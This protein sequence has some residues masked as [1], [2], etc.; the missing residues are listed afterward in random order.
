M[1]MLLI[2]KT[3]LFYHVI[4]NL[5]LNFFTPKLISD[6]VYNQDTAIKMQIQKSFKNLFL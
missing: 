5:N 4:N 6:Y 1:Y 3:N 2:K